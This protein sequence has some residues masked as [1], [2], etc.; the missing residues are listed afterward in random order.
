MTTIAISAKEIA[1]DSQLTVGNTKYLCAFEKVQAKHGHIYA[2]CGDPQ[3][4]KPAMKWVRDGAK[5][6]KSPKGAGWQLLV[7]TR[8]KLTLYDDLTR[9]GVDVTTP[10][11][12]G[13]GAD[14]A[15][16]VLENKGSARQ[17]VKAAAR[18]DCYTGYKVK[19]ID[20]SDTL[21]KVRKEWKI[22]RKVAKKK[23][24]EK[25][26]KAKAKRKRNK[27]RKSKR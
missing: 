2:F 11:C 14:V 23:V 24:K 9:H 6:S 4:F 17:A 1:Y 12:L 18:R 10:I 20:I 13:S 8:K 26:A 15:L 3:Y 7:V 21:K 5:H 22:E 19:V 16:G 25:K 27:K